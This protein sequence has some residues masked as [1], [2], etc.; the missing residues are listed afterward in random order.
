VSISILDFVLNSST[1]NPS[2]D[3]PRLH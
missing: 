2:S 3:I 1:L